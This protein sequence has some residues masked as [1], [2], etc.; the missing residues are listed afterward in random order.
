MDRGGYPTW[1]R[2]DRVMSRDGNIGV[3]PK[4]RKIGI[5]V[6]LFVLTVGTTYFV[7]LS[8]G[9]TGAA[10]YSGGIIIILLTHEMGHFL[11]ARKHGIPATLPYFIPVPLPPF[12]TMGAVIKMEG[13]IP[14]R[15]ALF[16]MG[17]AGPLAGLAMII[18]AI[19]IGT[20]MSRVVEVTSLGEGTISLG[21][22]LL[23]AFLARISVGPLPPG[24]E[25]LLHP[26]AF[27]G[28]VGLLV[29]ALNLLPVGQLDGGHITYALFWKRSRWIS[30]FFY[31]LFLSVCL[32]FY[33][34]WFLLIVVLALIRKHPPTMNDSLPLDRTR[35]IIGIFA[36]IVFVLAF[37]PVPFGFGEGLIP[38][39]LK[40][41]LP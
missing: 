6:L 31:I 2:P 16:D 39:L 29:T 4:K 40:E 18:P 13:R 36:L 26:L 30:R 22:S 10:W 17:V 5:H 21:D 38:M 14:D 25:L 32:F 28:W 11:M 9:W 1:K 23:F 8:D 24:Q 34:G 35:Q 15:R 20:R 12:G 3:A 41:F 33:F 37:T 7:G 27:A 19:L